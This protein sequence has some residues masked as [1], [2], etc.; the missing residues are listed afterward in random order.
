[1]QFIVRLT[2]AIMTYLSD[3]LSLCLP[4]NSEY[5]VAASRDDAYAGA[6]RSSTGRE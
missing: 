6:I 3:S 2:E 4:S 1:M 5:Y